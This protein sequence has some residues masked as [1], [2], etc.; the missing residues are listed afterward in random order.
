MSDLRQD[1][2]G[3]SIVELLITL[4]VIGVVFGAFMVTYTSIQAINKKSIDLNN[5]SNSAFAKLEE[6]ENKDFT[7]LPTTTPVNTLQEVEDFSG[8]LNA[9]LAKPRTGKVYINTVSSTLKQVVVNVQF[10]SD[11]R[12]VQYSAYIQRNGL[13]R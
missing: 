1:Q 8:T 4:I 3:F 12:T 2:N 6:Y 7:A 13:G 5:A 11:A 9:T 10:G